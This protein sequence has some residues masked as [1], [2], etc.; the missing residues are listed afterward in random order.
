[1]SHSAHEHAAHDAGIEPHAA[2]VDHNVFK[3]FHLPGFAIYFDHA[4]MLGPSRSNAVATK[5]FLIRN[6][7]IRR[8][9]Y[10]GRLWVAVDALREQIGTRHH[11]LRHW[12]HGEGFSWHAPHAKFSV[13][14]LDIIRADFQHHSSNAF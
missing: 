6:C 12:R 13:E 9:P 2:V 4:K 14:Q 3:N 1:M 8:V 11:E 7:A 10:V 5:A